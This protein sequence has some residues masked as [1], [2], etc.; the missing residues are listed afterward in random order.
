MSVKTLRRVARVVR[1]RPEPKQLPLLPPLPSVG[2]A[3]FLKNCDVRE[4]ILI[5]GVGSAQDVARAEELQEAYDQ[6]YET[7]ADEEKEREI[8]RA[9]VDGMLQS[10]HDSL[11]TAIEDFAAKR[12][13]PAKFRDRV[14]A[15]QDVVDFMYHKEVKFEEAVKELKKEIPQM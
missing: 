14:K 2:H 10:I 6:G 9:D 7:C 3:L 5:L 8:T 11:D 4:R 12:L 15:I 1:A 13:T